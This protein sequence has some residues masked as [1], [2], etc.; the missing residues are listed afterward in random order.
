MR[1]ISPASSP[2]NLIPTKLRCPIRSRLLF[3][4]F[5][6]GNTLVD[7]NFGEDFCSIFWV[8]CGFSGFV[9]KY[10][11]ELEAGP[12]ASQREPHISEREE[13]VKEKIILSQEKN[14]QRL[15]ELVQSLRRQLLQCK[16]E[17]E[18]VN[19]T[20]KPMTELLTVFD[21]QPMLDD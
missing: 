13:A 15:N 2:R 19:S 20:V 12:N 17:H 1:P 8:F 18:A 14:I 10:E 11:N 16:G 5:L 7:G 21:Q 9:W 3:S 6:G 4:A